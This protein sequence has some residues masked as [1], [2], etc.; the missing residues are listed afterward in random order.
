MKKASPADIIRMWLR[1]WGDLD[2]AEVERKA[3]LSFL[4]GQET[5]D[6]TQ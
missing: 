6:N 3:R 1:L 2:P 5:L 4:C